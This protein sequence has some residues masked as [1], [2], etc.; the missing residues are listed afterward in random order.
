MGIGQQGTDSGIVKG[1]KFNILFSAAY[2]AV[3]YIFK[4][5]YTLA[6][7]LGNISV[8]MAK[9]AVAT[10]TSW[11]IGAVLSAFFVAGGSVIAV[12]GIMLA[13]GIATASI[14]D[15]IDKKFKI[16]EAVINLIKKEIER[17]PKTPEANFNQ[18]LH[19]WGNY[20][21]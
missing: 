8:D 6:D 5:E 19:N 15:S 7:F 3:E 12:A 17:K 1:V 10:F 2:R 21:K 18:F 9:A 11:V 20:G 14:L 4:D 16:S 13:V